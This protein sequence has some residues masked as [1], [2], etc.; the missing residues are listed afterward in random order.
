MQ[1]VHR[2]SS[3]GHSG[4]ITATDLPEGIDRLC[5]RYHMLPMVI[6][7]LW[8]QKSPSQTGSRGDTGCIGTI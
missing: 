5:G 6:P 8:L 7:E 2:Q 4:A 3:N 1:A